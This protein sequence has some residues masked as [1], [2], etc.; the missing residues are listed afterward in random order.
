MS[1]IDTLES[2]LPPNR[3][4]PAAEIKLT[5]VDNTTGVK[6]LIFGDRIPAQRG[7]QREHNHADF[8][9]VHLGLPLERYTFGPY[10]RSRGDLNSGVPICPPDAS[11][12]PPNAVISFAGANVPKLLLSAPCRVLGGVTGVHV[13]FMMVS[14]FAASPEDLILGF[15]LRPAG[16]CNYNSFL[17]SLNE[18]AFQYGALKKFSASLSTGIS[19]QRVTISDLSRLGPASGLRRC[20]LCVY[21]MSDLPPGDIIHLTTAMV[22][23]SSV[24]TDVSPQQAPANQEVSPA[25]VSAGQP[26][27]TGL[28]AQAS[29]RGN[30]LHLS[31][32]GRR[33]GFIST[34]VTSLSP[35]MHDLDGAHQHQGLSIRQ[36]DGSFKGDGALLGYSLFSQCYAQVGEDG[37]DNFEDNLPCTGFKVSRSGVIGEQTT[38]FQSFPLASGTKKISFSFALRPETDAPKTRLALAVHLCRT[39]VTPTTTNN[40]CVSVAGIASVDA[41]GFV[42]G[43]VEPSETPGY[44][45]SGARQGLGLW[46]RDAEEAQAQAGVRLDNS[47]R[48]SRQI[49]LALLDVARITEMYT[50]RFQ[51]LLYADQTEATLDDDAGLLWVNGVA[52][53]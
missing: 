42:V 8:G 46:T 16:F 35:W 3:V 50:I 52:A 36:A 14:I 1:N 24:T 11:P 44:Q 38:F 27:L 25:Q 53:E 39:N 41:A 22:L 23:V 19:K 28:A 21:L 34:M 17:S 32:I 10:Y 26:L 20:E 5:W 48:I 9:G 47:Y 2:V 49:E 4:L 33:P 18:S 45:W 29:A 15:V 51:F 13:D 7:Y 12:P 31:T 6:E 40:S 37:A 43:T 30:A